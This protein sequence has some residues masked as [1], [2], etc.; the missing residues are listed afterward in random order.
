MRLKHFPTIETPEGKA[1]YTYI[2]QCCDDTL[3]TGWTNNLVNR[4]KVH[5]AGRGGKYTRLRIPVRLV[6]YE[7]S[8]S[9][10]RAMSLEARI[11]NLS[12]GEKELLISGSRSIE[13]LIEIPSK[14]PHDNEASSLEE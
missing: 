10:S 12:R 2:L 8:D 9:K 13:E 1:N 4:L 7:V 5:N 3:Y 14:E 11:K 6:H